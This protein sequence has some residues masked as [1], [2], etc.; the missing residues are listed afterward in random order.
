MISAGLSV[1]TGSVWCW[2]VPQASAVVG[3]YT[4]LVL[5]S[6]PVDKGFCRLQVMLQQDGRDWETSHVVDLKALISSRFV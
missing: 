5:D 4:P 6:S 2:R 3:P 1:G